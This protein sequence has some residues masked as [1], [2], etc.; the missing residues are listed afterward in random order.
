MSKAI[1]PLVRSQVIELY[2]SGSLYQSIVSI[3]GVSLRCCQSL[4]KQ[5]QIS[6]CKIVP[7]ENYS[8]CGQRSLGY[9]QYVYDKATSLKSE[10]E[11]WGA[12]LIRIKLGTLYPDISLP[13][14]RTL[15][16]WFLRAKVVKKK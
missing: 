6:G 2:E 9:P 15:S 11:G 4:V 7:V 12:G 3:T 16:G 1:S 10:R 13:S 8:L 14:E 5:W